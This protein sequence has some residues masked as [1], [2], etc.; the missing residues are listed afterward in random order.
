MLIETTVQP[1]CPVCGGDGAVVYN[2]LDDKMFA[3]PGVWRMRKCRLESCGTLWLDPKPAPHDI[4]KAYKNY[5]TH[6]D[7]F[8]PRE[9]ALRRLV[10]ASR[11][12][13]LRR[14]YGYPVKTGSLVQQLVSRLLHFYPLVRTASEFS[15][16]YLPFRANGSVLEVGCGS[17]Y[18]LD[19]LRRMGWTRLKG[20]DFDSTAVEYARSKGLDVDCGGLEDVDL[21]DTSVDA[22]IMSHV[23]EHLYS[24]QDVLKRA[25]ALLKPGGTL[26][27]VT[28]NAR[29]F[30]RKM[31]G[32]DWRGLEPPRHLQVFSPAGLQAL[33]D[34]AGFADVS[35]RTNVRGAAGM[36]AESMAIARG[37]ASSVPVAADSRD[38]FKGRILQALEML[39]LP[40]ARDRGEELV[41]VA[42][43]PED[44]S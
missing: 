17:G 36:F 29:A 33:C 15:V 34:S 14:K 25:F 27:L 41:V 18:L 23:I 24:P 39:A 21:P 16:M 38:R 1:T 2:G 28:P 32:R 37:V 22:V 8:V 4:G 44:A 19:N 42:K 11:G 7:D 20:V 35:W 30:G 5:Y 31:F 9:T 10:V 6:S 43:K 3:A 40:L 26:V 12:E 13:F